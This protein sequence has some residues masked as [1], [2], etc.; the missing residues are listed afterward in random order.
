MKVKKSHLNFESSFES[1][2]EEPTEG[3]EQRGEQAHDSGV[4]YE[5]KHIDV[6]VFSAKPI[7]IIS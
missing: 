5:W 3:A 1:A 4:E 7:F 2:G 6:R